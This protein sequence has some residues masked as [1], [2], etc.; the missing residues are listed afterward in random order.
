ML[1]VKK[2]HPDAKMPTVVHPGEDLGFDIYSIED[3]T[4]LPN[5]VVKIRTGIAAQFTPPSNSL[6]DNKFGLLIRDRS[7]M[8]SKN[9]TTSGGVIDASYDGEI[10]V[11]MT[12]HNSEDIVIKAGAKIAQLIPT[13]IMTQFEIKEVDELPNNTRGSKGF[14]SSGG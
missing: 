9:I 3:V 1:L 2:L 10:M 11:L 7:G 12:N 8:A 13:I 5:K 4:L 6:F 14:G